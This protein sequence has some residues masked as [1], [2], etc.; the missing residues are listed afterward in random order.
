MRYLDKAIRG[1]PVV[2]ERG[3]KVGKL[4][5]FV[6]DA[7]AHAVVQ[8]VVAKSRLLSALL[9]HDLLVAPDQVVSL[10]DER[11]VIRDEVVAAE[12]AAE[13]R[14]EQPAKASRVSMRSLE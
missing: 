13:I 6:L 2:T 5:G 14:V 3:E 11:M 12:V 1:V 8:Y 7:A 4:A 9:P 10:D